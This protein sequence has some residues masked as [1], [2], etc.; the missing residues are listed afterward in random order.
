MDMN[1]KR[2]FAPAMLALMLFAGTAMAGETTVP[3]TSGTR[4]IPVFVKVDSQG[5][6]ANMDPAPQLNPKLRRLLH[7]TL[8]QM[9][10]KPAHD[11]HGKPIASQFVINL[12]MHTSRIANGQYK[13]NFTYVSMQKVGVG[14]WHWA[15]IHMHQEP[16]LVNSDGAIADA[17]QRAQ[18]MQNSRIR[19]AEAARQTS[20][21]QGGSSNNQGGNGSHSGNGQQHP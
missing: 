1:M 3:S 21:Q 11:S 6:I 16:V 15:H 4:I 12:S 8:T 13:A 17:S 2:L 7:E 5:K 19:T 14:N 20:Q 9:I 10:N 18:Q